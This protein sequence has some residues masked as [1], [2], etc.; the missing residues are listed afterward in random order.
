MTEWDA[1]RIAA[2]EVTNYLSMEDMLR[3]TPTSRLIVR[4][5]VI[6][7]SVRIFP[8]ADM[9]HACLLRPAPGN[10]DRLIDEV[11]DYFKSRRLPVNIFVSPACTPPDLPARLVERGFRKQEAAEYWIT[12]D[13]PP[14]WQ[15]PAVAS[16][17]VAIK[18]IT[19]RQ[20]GLYA[21]IYLAGIGMPTI[22]APVMAF[23]LRRTFGLPHI[24]YY[25]AWLGDKPVGVGLWHSYGDMASLNGAAVLP[26]YRGS[27]V[28]LTFAAEA[29][30]EIHRQGI[31]TIVCQTVLRSM[32]RVLCYYGFKRAF[33]RDH[34]VL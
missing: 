31:H 11:T 12:L 14:G 3:A 2:L 23:L 7:T 5:D 8:M 18:Q 26:A 20:V 17:D 21:R 13:M 16:S 24:H 15:P 29:A 1:E 27:R 19:R 25:L 6:L 28:A 22:F 33:T 34:Y 10:V 4:D 32:Q 30:A 9:N